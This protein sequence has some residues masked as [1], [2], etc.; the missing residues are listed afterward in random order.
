L[1]EVRSPSQAGWLGPFIEDEMRA[2]GQ[3][4]AQGSIKSVYRRAAGPGTVI[5]TEGENIAAIRECMNTLP[6]RRRGAHDA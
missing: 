5:I 2:V 1:H 6:F 3:L 4:K